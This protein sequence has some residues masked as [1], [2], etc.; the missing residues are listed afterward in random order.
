[1]N[2]EKAIFKNAPK[3]NKT[4]KENNRNSF[5]TAAASIA[6]KA[7]YFGVSFSGLVTMKARPDVDEGAKIMFLA[8][9]NSAA[10]ARSSFLLGYLNAGCP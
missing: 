7:V 4:Q 9:T 5:Q 6:L 8:N 1:M 3:D 10:V 2:T